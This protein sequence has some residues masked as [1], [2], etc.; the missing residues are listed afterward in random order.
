MNNETVTID[1]RD[2]IRHGRE[3]LSKIMKAIR[4]LDP[5][6][7]VLLI[8]P[9]R[10]VPLFALLSKKGFV[11]HAHQVDNGDWEVVFMRAGEIPTVD[12]GCVPLR[13]GPAAAFGSP[14]S[15]SPIACEK[16]GNATGSKESQF[17]DVDARGLEPPQPMVKILEALAVLPQGAGVR[18]HTDRRPVHLY[19]QLE[20]RGFVGN[21]REQNDGSFITHISPR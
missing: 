7:Q 2:D 13:A 8:A 10:P 19:A 3:P 15:P 18:A 5:G 12:R 14:S 9:F 1:V 20:V 6:Q 16:I 4:D 17:I 11:H 21:S